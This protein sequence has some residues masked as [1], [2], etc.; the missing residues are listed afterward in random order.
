MRWLYL[1]KFGSFIGFAAGFLLLSK[2]LFPDIDVIRYA[3]LGPLVG[4]VSPPLW[5]RMADKCGGARV[6][7]WNLS[8][9]IAGG[10]GGLWPSLPV[11]PTR[12]GR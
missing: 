10:G 5:W 4:D 8:L 12:P 3:F 2:T 7:L 6:T 1:G 11:V 9:M